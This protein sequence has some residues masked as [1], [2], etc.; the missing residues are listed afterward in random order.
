MAESITLNLNGMILRSQLVV[1]LSLG[2]VKDQSDL[3]KV[4]LV[5]FYISRRFVLHTPVTLTKLTKICQD[6]TIHIIIYRSN[7]R[8]HPK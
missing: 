8:I 5:C 3:Q 1:L 6:C 4:L 2:L 7:A